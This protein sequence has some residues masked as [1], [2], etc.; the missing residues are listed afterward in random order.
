MNPADYTWPVPAAADTARALEGISGDIARGLPP[1]LDEALIVLAAVRAAG[2]DRPV[3]YSLT[4][5]AC[6]LLDQVPEG[7]WACA[8]CGDAWFGD[9]PDDGLCQACRAGE[10]EP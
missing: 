6:A 5:K 2:P 9:V 4:P 3:P 10:P 8:G 1:K 7:Q